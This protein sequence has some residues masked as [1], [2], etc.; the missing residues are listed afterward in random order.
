MDLFLA[1]LYGGGRGGGGKSFIGDRIGTVG[2]VG[3]EE[4]PA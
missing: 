4:L 3:E 2:L 1:A